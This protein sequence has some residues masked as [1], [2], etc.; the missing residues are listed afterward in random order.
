M[1]STVLHTLGE[2]LRDALGTVPLWAVRGLFVAVP[3]V[4]L[5]WVLR[6]PR[7]VTTSPTGKRGPA[8]NLKVGAAV[9]LLLQIV[10][11]LLL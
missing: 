3:V 9:A 10:I 11:Y 7:E 1:R 8:T 2:L 5:I 6:L 4:L